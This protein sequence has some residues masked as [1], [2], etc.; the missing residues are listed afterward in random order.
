MSTTE[1]EKKKNPFVIR[2]DGSI[3]LKNVRLSYANIWEARGFQ[4]SDAD[5]KYG[6]TLMLE[7]EEHAETIEALNDHMKGLAKSLGKDKKVGK[8]KLYLKDGDDSD[9]EEYAGHFIVRASSKRQ[10]EI[11]DAAKKPVT[12]EDE[13]YSGCYVNA[14]IRP[15]V[16]DNN[17]GIRINAELCAVQK[18]RD[19]ERFGGTRPSGNDA[20]DVEEGDDYDPFAEE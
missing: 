16:Q 6:A 12:D 18:V 3:V 2:E 13:V 11:L 4:G 7:K 9:K 15:W 10:P 5:V 1:T 19:G 8:D 14:L 17:F 20:F